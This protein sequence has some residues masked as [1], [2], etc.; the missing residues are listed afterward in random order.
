MLFVLKI[1][2]ILAGIE[3]ITERESAHPTSHQLNEFS[4]QM[5]IPPEIAPEP[6]TSLLKSTVS[7]HTLPL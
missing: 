7:S 5:L 6:T 2:Q 3:K 4:G 1:T